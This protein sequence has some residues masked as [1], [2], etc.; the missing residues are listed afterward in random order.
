GTQPLK[1]Q[2]EDEPQPADDDDHG[3]DTGVLRHIERIEQNAADASL[4][5]DHLAGDHGDQRQHQTGANTD[6]DLRQGGRQYDPQQAR[7]GPHAQGGGGP[8]ELFLDGAGALKAVVDHRKADA[9]DDD[10]GLGCI[11]NAEPQHNDRHQGRLGNGINHHQQRI[12]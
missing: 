1:Q 9:Q 3:V 5:G 7:G 2:V 10:Y 8:N 11:A 12:E 6:K 4:A